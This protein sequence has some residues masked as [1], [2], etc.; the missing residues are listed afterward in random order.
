M[1]VW[2][3]VDSEGMQTATGAGESSTGGGVDDVV[4]AKA[5]WQAVG[6]CSGDDGEPAT[7]GEAEERRVRAED[8]ITTLRPIMEPV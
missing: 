5:G 7:E 8:S 3:R 2:P 6:I 4:R 1:T